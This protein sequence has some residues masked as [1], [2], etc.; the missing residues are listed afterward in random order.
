MFMSI[1]IRFNAISGVSSF[2]CGLANRALPNNSL[3]AKLFKNVLANQCRTISSDR[4]EKLLIFQL[5][6]KGSL[7]SWRDYMKLTA[8]IS[9]YEKV[10]ASD[11][12]G[13]VFEKLPNFVVEKGKWNKPLRWEEQGNPTSLHLAVRKKNLSEIKRLI[14]GGADV[15]AP[16]VGGRTPLFEAVRTGKPE[17]VDLLMSCGADPNKY[18]TSSWNY[19]YTAY[20]YAL[21][22]KFYAI[23]RLFIE[24]WGVSA[25][26][27]VEFNDY[28][29]P[30]EAIHFAMPS[31]N[32]YK[33]LTP[34]KRSE[35]EKILMFLLDTRGKRFIRD[36]ERF[37]SQAVRNNM[38]GVVKLMIEKKATLDAYN[39]FCIDLTAISV[40]EFV[41][42]PD[43]F[44]NILH[45]I[46][47]N[48]REKG[49]HV[50]SLKISAD[51]GCMIKGAIECGFRHHHAN[52]DYS[53][54]NLCLKNHT[55]K[56]C[57]YPPF[58]TISAGVTAVVFDK[59]LKNVLV[60]MESV[61]SIKKIKP[62]TGTVEYG[63]NQ[64]TPLEAV[65]R[66]LKE[67]TQIEVDPAKAFHVGSTWSN[68][69][70]G[71][72]PDIAFI[73]A[74]VLDQM[75]EPVAQKSEISK[76]KWVSVEEYIQVLPEEIG[77]P[78]LLRQ[79]VVSA[80]EAIKNNKYWK[81]KTVYLSTGNKVDL[82]TT[83]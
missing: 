18:E 24:K 38:Q 59:E 44:Q 54:L 75:K 9:G 27:P 43:F 78:W 65:V 39:G 77:K 52:S 70:R 68:N 31:D 83:E 34:F 15:N 19:N 11:D 49:F 22:K 29:W 64:E 71:T 45:S 20:H 82:F 61:G 16:G 23:T 14:R 32:E 2:Y 28:G 7:I 26:Q 12:T 4:R 30:P 60:V 25:D 47:S 80:F 76:A 74:F 63:Q 6:K 17:L 53:L 33:K 73:F 8:T 46:I 37:F 3:E 55:I 69:Y 40:N 48:Q 62:P 21:Q 36:S 56:E 58:R 57:T 42:K 5:R 72:N 1:F 41:S 10:L 66:E 35:A 79:V 50:F 51:N 81:P 67:E 13:V